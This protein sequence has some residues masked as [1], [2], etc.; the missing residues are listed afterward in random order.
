L[1][2]N[3]TN[4][5][6]KPGVQSKEMTPIKSE[7]I[8]PIARM[9]SL[10]EPTEKPDPVKLLAKQFN[11]DPEALAAFILEREIEAKKAAL[12]QNEEDV[13]KSILLNEALKN[14]TGQALTQPATRPS[15]SRRE[16]RRETVQPKPLDTRTPSSYLKNSPELQRTIEEYQQQSAQQENKFNPPSRQQTIQVFDEPSPIAKEK[17]RISEKHDS[18][19]QENPKPSTR[20]IEVQTSFIKDDRLY[21]KPQTH[22]PNDL[23]ENYYNKYHNNILSPTQKTIRDLYKFKP[24]PSKIA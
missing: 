13:T 20:A 23:I 16:T 5:D 22:N 11:N 7:D 1:P 14:L 12:A 6:Y 18:I 19:K 9:Q 10:Q 3:I 15:Q 17:S 24:K 8:S 2:L 4:F 21:I